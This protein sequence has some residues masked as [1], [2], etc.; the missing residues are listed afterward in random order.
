MVKKILRKYEVSKKF[1][2]PLAM[3]NLRWRTCGAHKVGSPLPTEFFGVHESG[4]ELLTTYLRGPSL[5][6][7][8]SIHCWTDE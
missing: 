4:I 3:I 2:P 6:S 7:L 8:E 1:P 5:L